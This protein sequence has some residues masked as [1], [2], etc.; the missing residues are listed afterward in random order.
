MSA[1]KESV[2]N[3]LQRAADAGLQ[4]R[5][6]RQDKGLQQRR[7][8]GESMSE[9]TQSSD[10]QPTYP[11][12]KVYAL[13]QSY[14]QQLAERDETIDVLRGKLRRTK[15]GVP[16]AS[17]SAR[18][19]LLACMTEQ[20]QKIDF[21]VSAGVVALLL[22]AGGRLRRCAS[23][24]ADYDIEWVELEVGGYRFEAQRSVP[25]ADAAEQQK[26]G[27]NVQDR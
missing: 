3:Q 21:G 20:F 15:A 22:Q 9:D 19:L 4:D 10:M 8:P 5:K 24:R 26:E 14:H 13:V 11:A 27:E 6:S 2:A 1:T 23:Q 16:P 17:W 18:E 12:E 25:R 7:E